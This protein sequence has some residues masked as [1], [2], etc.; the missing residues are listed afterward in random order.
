MNIEKMLIVTKKIISIIINSNNNTNDDDDGV[1]ESDVVNKK[2]KE[3]SKIDCMFN[4]RYRVPCSPSS[5]DSLI[6]QNYLSRQ[7]LKPLAANTFW[8]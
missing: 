8:F 6:I 1:I 4:I 2:N 5:A 3:D 7:Q